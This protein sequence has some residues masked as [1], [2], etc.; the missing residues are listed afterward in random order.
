[1][2]ETGHGFQEQRQLIGQISVYTSSIRV[3]LILEMPRASHPKGDEY[4]ALDTKI[5]CHFLAIQLI[6]KMKILY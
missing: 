1:M 2:Y 4:E 6:T 3:C 5:V